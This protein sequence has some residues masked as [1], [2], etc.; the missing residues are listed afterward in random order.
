[1][2]MPS[3]PRKRAPRG[4]SKERI[5]T[6]L[7]SAELLAVDAHAEREHLTRSAMARILILRGMAAGEKQPTPAVTQRHTTSIAED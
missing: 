6:A 1:M 5:Y 2:G 3:L 4:C 7:M